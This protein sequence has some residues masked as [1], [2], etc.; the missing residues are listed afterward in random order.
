[1]PRQTCSAISSI[2]YANDGKDFSVFI[3]WDRIGSERVG[4]NYAKR[5]ILK[6]RLKFVQ[7]CSSRK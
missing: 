3:Y 1:V 2:V 7:T 5:R 6:F 4:H